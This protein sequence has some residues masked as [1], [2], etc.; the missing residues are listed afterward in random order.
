MFDRVSVLLV[1]S[2]VIING[3]V[4]FL[5]FEIGMILFS[6]VLLIILILFILF[7]NFGLF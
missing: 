4:V 6:F 1:K 5:V 2:D 3:R 7:L